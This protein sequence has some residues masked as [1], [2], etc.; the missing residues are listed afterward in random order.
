VSKK[1]KENSARLGWARDYLLE[2]FNS[3]I[4]RMSEG[5]FSDELGGSPDDLIMIQKRKEQ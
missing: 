4:V 5:G 3:R 1:G 2:F